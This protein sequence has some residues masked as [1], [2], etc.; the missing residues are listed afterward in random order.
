MELKPGSVKHPKPKPNPSIKKIYLVYLDKAMGPKEK[1][2]A[3]A[4]ARG[5]NI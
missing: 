1:P 4:D 3:S 2:R 5:L